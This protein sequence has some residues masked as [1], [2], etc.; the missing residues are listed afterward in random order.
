MKKLLIMFI[1]GLFFLPL[2]FAEDTHTEIK[3]SKK[4]INTLKEYMEKEVKLKP[5]RLEYNLSKITKYPDI[6]LEFE[7]W[8]VTR[9]YET[10]NPVKIE[11]YTAKDIAKLAPFM[12]GL[13]VYNF[14]ITLRENPEDALWYIKKGFPVY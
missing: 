11:G 2:S 12:K 5:D 13:G 10:E 14:M 1:I 4:T 8:I 6:C 3:L 9:K 7:K